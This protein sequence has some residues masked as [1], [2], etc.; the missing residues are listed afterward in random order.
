MV[1]KILMVAMWIVCAV[2][3]VLLLR[4]Y[5]YIAALWVGSTAL[6]VGHSWIWHSRATK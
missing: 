5:N 3:L 2:A 4:E 6:W 1:I